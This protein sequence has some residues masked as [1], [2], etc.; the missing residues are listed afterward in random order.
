MR[1]QFLFSYPWRNQ[2][3]QV[4]CPH[5]TASCAITGCLSSSPIPLL[6]SKASLLPLRVTLTHFAL[7]SYK[8]ALR[9]PTSFPILGLARLGVKPRLGRSFWR[10]FTSSYP[11]MCS[12]TSPRDALFACPPPPP[13]NPSFV[14]VK[15]TLSSPCYRSNLSLSLAKVWLSLTLT[16]YHLTI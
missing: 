16:L 9:L 10:A 8:R 13:R 3:C 12:P 1:P 14:R 6:F 2:H 4:E 15:L 7:F 5:R 11:L